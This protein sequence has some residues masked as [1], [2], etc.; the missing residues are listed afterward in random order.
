MRILISSHFYAPSIG[1]IETVTALLAEEWI[2]AGHDVRIITQTSDRSAT[3]V[4]PCAVIRNPSLAKLFRQLAWCDLYFQNNISLKTLW[5]ALLLRKPTVITHQTWFPRGYAGFAK[6]LACRLVARTVA[7]SNAVRSDTGGTI[8]IPNPYQMDIFN[9]DPKAPRD[10]DLLF[11][12]RLVS[13]KGTDLLI[14]ALGVL[15][16]RG[17]HPRLSIVGDGPELKR[18]Q[19]LGE[20]HGLKHQI[21]FLGKKGGSELAILLRRH[22]ILIVPS[23]WEEP[24][25]IVALEGI[26]CGCAVI[27]SDRGGLPEA[28][29][30]C[31][32]L[33]PNG[34]A[35]IL[36]GQLERLLNSEAELAKVTAPSLRKP[37]LERHTPEQISSEYLNL[38]TA[39]LGGDMHHSGNLLR[40]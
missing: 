11:V 15:A 30:P 33:F 10:G 24:F 1:G 28:I 3:Q 17:L 6:R 37:H 20:Q 29:G 14:D 9:E 25:G 31:G 19:A 34:N 5:P 32:L 40:S 2:A 39:L 7:I 36:A 23:R 13:D 16:R 38:F 4:H 21:G 27:G 35:E 18:L 8:V 12:G 26:A 22:R